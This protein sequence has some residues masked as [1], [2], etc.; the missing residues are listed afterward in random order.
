MINKIK[1]DLCVCSVVTISR[2]T[3]LCSCRPVVDD[4]DD[5]VD[6]NSLLCV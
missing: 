3:R 4:S 5:E 2:H 1:E 6:E